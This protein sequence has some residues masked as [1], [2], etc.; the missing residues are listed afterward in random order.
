MKRS[1]EQTLWRIRG[2]YLEMPGMSLT[3]KQAQRLWGL[4][5]QACEELLRTLVAQ[6]FLRQTQTG[7]FVR[8]TA[9]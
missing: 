5:Q 1:A 6:R 7:V 4:D 8:A 2:E 9:A 3:A